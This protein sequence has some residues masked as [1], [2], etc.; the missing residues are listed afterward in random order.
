MLRDRA[1]YGEPEEHTTEASDNDR[2]A[3]SG[4]SRFIDL[5][6]GYHASGIGRNLREIP[7]LGPCG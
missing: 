1:E 5:P 3:G 7:F 2:E 6:D 4:K